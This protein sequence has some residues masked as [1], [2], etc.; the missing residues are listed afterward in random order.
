MGADHLSV[1]GPAEAGM[2]LVGKK[3]MAAG[4]RVA[5]K[6]RPF[7]TEVPGVSPR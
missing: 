1:I 2:P 4:L 5:S 7:E 3:S 6:K